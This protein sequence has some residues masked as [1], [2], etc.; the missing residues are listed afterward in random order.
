MVVIFFL[1]C[2]LTVA[3]FTMA[4]HL[5]LLWFFKKEEIAE[6]TVSLV[7]YF[8]VKATLEIG[9]KSAADKKPIWII[10]E[11]FFPSLELAGVL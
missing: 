6:S 4:E 9:R 8:D 7:T 10:Y 3:G 5:A 2:K 11:I 1:F